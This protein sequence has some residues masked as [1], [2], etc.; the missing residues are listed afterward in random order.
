MTQKTKHEVHTRQRPLII[1]SWFPVTS[2]FFLVLTYFPLKNM[3]LLHVPS[4]PFLSFQSVKTYSEAGDIC[5][6]SS[7]EFHFNAHFKL[8]HWLR[9]ALLLVIVGLTLYEKPLL[10]SSIF[11]S[12]QQ[13][14]LERSKWVSRRSSVLSSFTP[15]AA[16]LEGKLSLPFFSESRIL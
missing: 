13:E 1:T 14:R 3:Q 11:S 10:S 7:I 6:F 5:S 4:S 9:F 12:L 2:H 8:R 15:K 16:S